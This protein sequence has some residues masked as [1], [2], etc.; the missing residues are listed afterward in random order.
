MLTAFA[1]FLR[2]RR[3]SINFAK[4]GKDITK[5]LKANLGEIWFNEN[6]AGM[7]RNQGDLYIEECLHYLKPPK[8]TPTTKK[9][10]KKNY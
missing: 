6:V 5:H 1:K 9:K 3:I 8:H 2:D 7:I 4:N 10:H